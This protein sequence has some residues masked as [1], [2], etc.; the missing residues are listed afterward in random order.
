MTWIAA[1]YDLYDSVISMGQED[2]KIK[3]YDM[4][5][6]GMSGYSGVSCYPFLSLELFD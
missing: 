4:L 5:L 1:F 2:L 6:W 3:F